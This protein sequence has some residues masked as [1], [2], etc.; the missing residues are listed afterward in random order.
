[1]IGEPS[2]KIRM[3]SRARYLIALLLV[4]SVCVKASHGGGKDHDEQKKK[5]GVTYDGTSLIINGKRRLLFSGSIHYPRS[6]PEVS[7]STL[8]VYDPIKKMISFYGSNFV[9]DVAQYH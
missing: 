3:K 1:M 9:S 2:S 8:F 7:R 4:V 5:K 6:T